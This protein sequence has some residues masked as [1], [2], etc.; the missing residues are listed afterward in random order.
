[1]SQAIQ[2]DID[3]LVERIRRGELVN[4]QTVRA[5]LGCGYHNAHTACEQAHERQCRWMLAHFP[6]PVRR[7]NPRS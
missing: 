5:E 7:P 2:I 6:P 1:M 3:Q 4:A